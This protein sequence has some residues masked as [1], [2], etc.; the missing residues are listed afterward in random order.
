MHRSPLKKFYFAEKVCF[1]YL[2]TTSVLMYFF[3]VYN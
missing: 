2:I 3:S 1:I